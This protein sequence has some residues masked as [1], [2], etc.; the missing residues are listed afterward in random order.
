MKKWLMGIASVAA[1]AAGPAIAADMPAPTYKAPPVAAWTWAGFYVGGH[2]GYGWGENSFV[3]VESFAPLVVLDGISSKGWVFGAQAGY[4]WQFG[5]WVVGLELDGSA[6]DINGTVGPVTSIPFAGAVSTNAR[7]D[8]VK[9]LGT[10]R[11]RVGYAVSSSCCWNAMI[12]GTAG[13]AWERLTESFTTSFAVPPVPATVNF[14]TNPRDIFGWVAGA[15]IDLQLGN[16]NWIARAEYLHYDFGD[17]QGLGVQIAPGAAPL[18][19]NTGGSQR[20]DVVRGA[21]SYKFTP[22]TSY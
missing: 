17:T 13:L 2:G 9:Y 18:V 20:I 8:D 16:T 19:G 22:G 15:G 14:G 12:Y 4:N 7:G 6:T 11:A 21:L 10:A 5:P 1:L 3:E